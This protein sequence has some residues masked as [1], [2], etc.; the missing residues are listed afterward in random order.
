MEKLLDDQLFAAELLQTVRILDL[1]EA[2]PCLLRNKRSAE[3]CM[4]SEFD[5]AAVALANEQFGLVV[6]VETV[7]VAA[8][9]L[10]LASAMHHPLFV[11][12]SDHHR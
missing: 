7:E 2:F 5:V 9:L 1:V 12:A 4:A 8:R 11:A 3:R 6:A 10:A